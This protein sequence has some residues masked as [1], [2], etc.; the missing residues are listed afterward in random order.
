MKC[1]EQVGADTD[2]LVLSGSAISS[3]GM[4]AAM[5]MSWS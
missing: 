5:I 2:E 3:I 4:C 1:G